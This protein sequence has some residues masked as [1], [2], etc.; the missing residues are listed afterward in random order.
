MHEEQRPFA[1]VLQAPLPGRAGRPR[2]AG[3]TMLLD[4]GLGLAAT[5][6]LLAISGPYIDWL[7][8]GFG[9]AAL[10]TTG[11][12]RSKIAL[13][14]SFGVETYP[15]GTFCEV[16]LSQGA[17]PQYLTRCRELGFCWIEVSDGT[18]DLEPYR[19]AEAIQAAHEAGFQVLT[20]IGKKDGR[21]L[22]IGLLC[23]QVARDL[24]AGAAWVI[25]E[26]RET[27]R[28]VGLLDQRGQFDAESLERLLAGVPEPGRLIWEAPQK[29]Q[30][31]YLI[32]RLGPAVN[33][34][35]IP[36]GEALALEAMRQGLRGDTFRLALER[37]EV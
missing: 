27:G 37:S 28:G 24:E 13:A 25:V 35:N 20:E 9:T 11:L 29:E 5:E 1:G 14:R 21:R 16:A 32:T 19:R 31:E 18:I 26:G 23:E 15:G 2:E 6:D 33:L 7:K 8:L 36:T 30:Q 17:L 10:Y 4:K 12:L 34:G 22:P 3:L